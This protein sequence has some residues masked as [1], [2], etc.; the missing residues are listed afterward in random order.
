MGYWSEYEVLP[1]WTTT[2]RTTLTNKTS[3]SGATPEQWGTEEAV[4]DNAILPIPTGTVTAY[5]HLTGYIE[6]YSTDANLVVQVEISFDG[7]STWSTSPNKSVKLGVTGSSTTRLSA[8][9][10]YSASG[11]VTGDIQARVMIQSSGAGAVQDGMN[12]SI[13]LLVHQQLS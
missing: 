11:T 7:G 13:D 10:A 6:N 9:M 5:A 2:T 4:V 8:S 3:F 1:S 12:G